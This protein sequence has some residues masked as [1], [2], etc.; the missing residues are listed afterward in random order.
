MSSTNIGIA[1][2][3]A[4]GFPVQWVIVLSSSADP[5]KPFDGPVW[6]GT[7]IESVNGR[8]ES[9]RQCEQGLITFS[10][11]LFLFGVVNVG[12]IN[13]PESNIRGSIFNRAWSAQDSRSGTNGGKYPPTDAYVRQVLSYLCQKKAISLPPR[14]KNNFSGHFEG[15]LSRIGECRMSN[16]VNTCPVI[17]IV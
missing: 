11:H 8:V 16:M 14:V 3:T 6:C 12:N 10:P 4:N 15:L 7:L 5:S 17:P 1:F 9:W 2:Y 13:Q